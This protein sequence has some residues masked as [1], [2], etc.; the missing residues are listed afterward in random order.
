ML[1]AAAQE[2]REAMR[3]FAR[4]GNLDVWYARMA[5]ADVFTRAR[6]ALSAKAARK[7][8]AKA[9][10]ARAKDSLR[11]LDRLTE[12]V[13]GELR[14]VSQPPL[15]VRAADLVSTEE[16]GKL[17][18]SMREL[19]RAYGES[20]P[21]DR[22]HLLEGYRFVDMARKVVGV[23]SVGTRVWVVLLVGRDDADPLFLQCKEAG[24]SALAPFVGPQG[25][26]HHGRR[27]VEGQRLMQAA[28]DILLGWVQGPGL[29]DGGP[30]DYYVRQ[31]WD[32]KQSAAV[33]EMTA[34]TLTAYG[35]LCAW[36]LARAHARSGDRIAIAAY[37]G[38]RGR[39]DRA[40]ADFAE[41][42]ADQNERDYDALVAAA[43]EGRLITDA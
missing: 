17:G 36:T 9:S 8:K 3:E 34:E 15:I 31:L 35:R 20:L 4:L 41:V 14:I 18:Q 42:Y 27:V 33:E 7:V 2:Y 10:R 23:G 26:G 5:A 1:V 6:D 37:L 39:F 11:A 28:S 21:P 43:D 30:R 38:K 25:P 19:L 32:W 16:A 13:D 12:V 29:L 40:V 22:R 24:P